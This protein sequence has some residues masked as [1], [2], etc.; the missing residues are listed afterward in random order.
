M[1]RDQLDRY[2]D[3]VVDDERG[4][5]LSRLVAAARSAGLELWGVSVATVP[6]G[7][8]KDHER[9]ELLRRKN[10]TL[11]DTLKFGRGIGRSTGLR[12]VSDTW[13]AA[14][15][16]TG[17]LDRHVGASTIPADRTRRGR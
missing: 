8:P 15:P 12:F 13:R 10:L 9:I 3:G 7:Y 11:G 1:A 2:R 16:V 14:A 6:R 17:W 5:E 4:A